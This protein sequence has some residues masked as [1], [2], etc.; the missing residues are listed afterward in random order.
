MLGASWAT[1]TRDGGSGAFSAAD[2]TQLM[3]YGLMIGGFDDGTGGGGGGAAML[4][5]S[6]GLVG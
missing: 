1:Y 4:V 3:N 2:G 5:N 6:G